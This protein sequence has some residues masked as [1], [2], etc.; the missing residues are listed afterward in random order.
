MR[1]AIIAAAGGASAKKNLHKNV[2]PA[3]ARP[4]HAGR[5]AG[6]QHAAWLSGHPPPRG[7]AEN[8]AFR[9]TIPH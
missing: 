8:H 7:S 2:M 9:L 1:I 4:G 3:A 6:M 5:G